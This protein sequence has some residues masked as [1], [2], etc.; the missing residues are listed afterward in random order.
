LIH[1]ERLALSKCRFNQWLWHRQRCRSEDT[2]ISK[3]WIYSYL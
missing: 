2:S 3:T 1:F